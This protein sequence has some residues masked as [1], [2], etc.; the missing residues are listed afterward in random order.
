[1]KHAL[2]LAIDIVS[3][4]LAK[5]LFV[6]NSTPCIF[7]LQVPLGLLLIFVLMFFPRI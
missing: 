3:K 6:S 5:A 2:E 4:D 7:M 1:M